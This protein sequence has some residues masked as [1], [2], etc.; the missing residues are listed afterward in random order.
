[1]SFGKLNG[2]AQIVKR[3]ISKDSAGFKVE[4][5]AIIANV[6][7]YHEQRHS[8]YRWANLAAF[9]EATDR[10]VIRVKS[11]LDVNP[12]FYIYYKNVW[13]K[14]LSVEDVKERGMYLEMYAERVV[15]VLG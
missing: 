15:S 6:R 12:G 8:S 4:N 11:A 7:C 14:I 1:M 10:F 9:S 2:F 3:T 13:Y 5:D